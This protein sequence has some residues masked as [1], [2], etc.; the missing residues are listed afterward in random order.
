MFTHLRQFADLGISLRDV[1][2]LYYIASQGT[3]VTHID[4]ANALGL[5]MD[6]GNIRS[7]M[8]KLVELGLIDRTTT[9]NRNLPQHTHLIS[10][11]C[12]KLLRLPKPT[13]NSKPRTENQPA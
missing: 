7:A 12:R 11:T 6:N 2:V 5:R 4:I 13:E 9:I 3:S 8:S 1:C 10:A